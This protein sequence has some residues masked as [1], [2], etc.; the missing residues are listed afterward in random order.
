MSQ[1]I[2]IVAYTYKERMQTIH[3]RWIMYM[4][5]FLALNFSLLSG[6]V[7]YDL[8]AAVKDA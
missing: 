6:I 4:F 1:W 5:I 7:A 3:V 2:E 8:Q